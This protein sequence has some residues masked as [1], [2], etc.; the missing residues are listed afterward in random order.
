MPPLTQVH[1]LQL[2]SKRLEAQRR[3]VGQLSYSVTGA[4]IFFKRTDMD[5]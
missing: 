5:T 2:T 1:T 4:T 3:E